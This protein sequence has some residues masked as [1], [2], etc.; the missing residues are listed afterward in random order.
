[1]SAT[2]PVEVAPPEQ[3]IAIT[4]APINGY[5]R[6]TAGENAVELDAGQ[7]GTEETEG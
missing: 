5:I 1:M 6:P 3:P 7:A 2:E 4:V